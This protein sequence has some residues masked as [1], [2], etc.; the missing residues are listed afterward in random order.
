M[1][2]IAASSAIGLPSCS[3][4]KFDLPDYTITG[5]EV[6]LSVP[7]QLPEMEKQT[8]A[9]L[10]E[11]SLNR[12]ESLWIRTY[13]ADTGEATSEW[14]ILTPN[15]SDTEIARNVELQTKSGYSYIVGVANVAN[16]GVLKSD[17]STQKPL[18]EL[19]TEANDWESFLDIAVVSPSTQEGTRVPNVPLPMAGCYTDIVAGGAHPEPAR[20]DE[21]QMKDFTPY[22]IPAQR[23]PVNFQGAIHL[24]RLVSHI[25]FNIIPGNNNIDVT[26]N[27]YQIV[28]APRFSWLYERP[29]LSGMNANFGDMS[30]RETISTYYA[31]NIQFGSQYVN[32]NDGTSSFDFWQAESKHTGT[33][34]TYPQRDERN[35][36]DPTLFT[37]LTGDIWSPNNMASYVLI[38]CTVDYHNQINVDGQGEIMTDNSGTN[39]YRTGQTTYLIHL[40]YIGDGDESEKSKDFNC[41]RNVDYT[42]NVTVNGLNDIR[43]D[44]WADDETFHGEEGIVSDLQYSTIELDAH[45]HA[46]NIELTQEEL[47]DPNFGFI[48]TTYE[49][50]NVYTFNSKEDTNGV[51]E[52][53]YNWIE[54]RATTGPNDLAEYKSRFQTLGSNEKVTFL[55]S[56]LEGNGVRGPWNLSMTDLMKSNTGWYTVFVNE[57]TYE[58]IYR[59]TDGYANEV[60]NGTGLRPNWM[61]YVNQNPRRFY[62][63]V[64]RSESADG[65]SIYTRSKYGVSQRSIQTYYSDQ[66][67]TPVDGDLPRGTAIGVERENETEGLNLRHTFEGGSSVDNG[68]WNIAQWL[69]NS[70]TTTNPSINNANANNRPLWSTFVDQTAPMQVGAVGTARAQGGLELP[71]R[72]IASGNPV[73]LPKVVTLTGQTSTFNDPQASG[74][75]YIEAINAC[76][77]RNRDNN[78]NGRIEPDELRWYVPAMGKYLRM[79]L[80]SESLSEPLMDFKNITALPYVNNN[81]WNTTTGIIQNDYYSRYMFISS[82]TGRNVLWGMEGTS[83]SQYGDPSSWSGTTIR[84]WQVRCIRNLGSN[85]TTV[86][87]SDKVTKAYV[88]DATAHTFKMTYYD[89]ASIRANS[90]SSNGTSLGSMPIH[91]ITSP[92]NAVYFGFEYS[93]DDITIPAA[94]RPATD[95]DNNFNNQYNRLENY[96]NGNPCASAGLSGTGWRIPNQKE[97]TMMR[98]ANLFT[99]YAN[100]TTWLTC[101]VNYF[102]YT[103]GAGNDNTTN[104][105]YLV[106]TP[107]QGTQ[108]TRNN[109]SSAVGNQSNGFFIRCVR[110]I[111][112]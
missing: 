110:D 7:I 83:T 97:L 89:G 19:L 62:I 43:V 42:Y 5:A 74:D 25:N 44:A 4:D 30:T 28:N 102:D 33:S 48:I 85:M 2:A 40:G 87:Q 8:R 66:V 51:D 81:Q 98:N 26:V 72:T 21:W 84:P 39:V 106:I 1:L 111:N 104:K 94:S 38:S 32:V 65:N 36:A 9:D 80:G 37:G 49:N 29:T 82:N 108:L 78:G 71:A 93:T 55:L 34:T 56:D 14:K 99:S 88:H 50:G 12:V 73:K 69:S 68:R 10:D 13:S 109:M 54:L 15:S 101:T 105:R 91:T 60:W 59:G 57:Y 41:F 96:I 64:T 3:D 107:L 53:L 95:N 11:I 18:S 100:N 6:T 20:L 90:Y 23:T 63:R 61:G 22:F 47:S 67:F 24:R 77:S 35:E 27:S 86:T 70:S 76:M 79:I 52:N 17:P 75:Y 112:N 45:Y 46:F 103:N 16:M 31:D 58:P 92:Y